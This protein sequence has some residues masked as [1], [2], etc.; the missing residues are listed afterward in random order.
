M[1]CLV[2]SQKRRD[3]QVGGERKGETVSFVVGS[4]RKKDLRVLHHWEER[5]R[6]GQ[7]QHLNPLPEEKT[8][9]KIWV[10]SPP[11]AQRDCRARV[12]GRWSRGICGTTKSRSTQPEFCDPKRR[13]KVKRSAMPLA[14]KRVNFPR[15]LQTLWNRWSC[16]RTCNRTRTRPLYRLG[17]K[18]T[19]PMDWICRVWGALRHFRKTRAPRKEEKVPSKSPNSRSTGKTKSKAQK[20]GGAMGEKSSSQQGRR[21]DYIIRKPG[22]SKSRRNAWK[23]LD[24]NKKEKREINSLKLRAFARPKER[25]RGSPPWRRVGG[26]FKASKPSSDQGRGIGAKLS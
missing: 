4:K 21:F 8:Q 5:S 26:K 24:Q 2:L 11:S 15:T 16:V 7:G 23:D 12:Q 10:V 3:S 18:G 13:K 6:R 19:R 25:A 20:R 22:E 1:K 9:E 17:K 14:R